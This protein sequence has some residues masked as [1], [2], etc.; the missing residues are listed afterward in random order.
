[1]QPVIVRVHLGRAPFDRSRLRRMAC[2]RVRVVQMPV[3]PQVP[4]DGAGGIVQ[5]HLDIALRIETADHSRITVRHTELLIRSGELHVLA[6][7]KLLDPI[8]EN[9]NSGAGSRRIV[10]QHPAIFGFYGE[11]VL[12]RVGIELSSQVSKSWWSKLTPE[13]KTSRARTA[14]EGRWGKKKAAPRK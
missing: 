9:S 4:F 10:A 5:H 14:A 1:M 3:V 2:A 13:E 12:G 8:L 11:L 6:D 7:C